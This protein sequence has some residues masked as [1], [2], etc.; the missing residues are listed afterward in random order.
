MGYFSQ[1]TI[2]EWLNDQSQVDIPD[3][4]CEE[5]SRKKK[6]KSKLDPLTKK[7]HYSYSG[8]VYIYD[9]KVCDYWI[10]YTTAKSKSEAARNLAYRFKEEH[11]WPIRSK[12]IFPNEIVLEE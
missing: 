9:H 12:L 2:D 5:K 6:K 8:P 3:T 4:P 10:G 7:A 1:M 11:K